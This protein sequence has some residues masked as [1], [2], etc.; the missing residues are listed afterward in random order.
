[1]KTILIIGRSLSGKTTRIIDML[2]KSK[3]KSILFSPENPESVV[4][5]YGLNI[6][7]DIYDTEK[8]TMKVVIMY[9]EHDGYVTAGID[10]IELLPKDFDLI[11]LHQYLM[12]RNFSQFIMTSHLHRTHQTGQRAASL[13]TALQP[14][15]L[16][17]KG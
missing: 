15:I 11:A 9:L 5:S 13:V 4:R 14:T 2:N 7:H 8:L 17:A 16:R 3:G 6:S 12:S 10:S 1:M